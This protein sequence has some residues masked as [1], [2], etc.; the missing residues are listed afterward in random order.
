MESIHYRRRG[1]YVLWGVLLLA[2][3][4]ALGLW[5]TPQRSSTAKLTLRLKVND[6][7]A[8]TQ[9]KVWAGPR[10]RWPGAA[11]TGL[12]AAAAIQP[13]DDKV[14]LEVLPLPV[15]Y[16]R[17]GKDTIPRRTA[18]LVVLRFEA[19]GQAPRYLVL[20]LGED[21]RSGLLRPGRKMS[22]SMECRWGG[23]GT[24]PAGFA[25]LE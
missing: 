25:R 13:T 17:W 5:E 16:R 9:V 22:V 3:L 1:F 18:D 23:L 15:A 14:A 20:P 8:Q 11:W 7:P 2:S 4:I 19:P 21:W 6:L 24:D 12:G 10:G